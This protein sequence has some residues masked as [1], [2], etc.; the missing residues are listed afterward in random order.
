MIYFSSWVCCPLKFQG[1]PQPHHWECFLVFGNF[2][3][4]KDSLPSMNLHPYLFC[5]SFYLSY[6]FLLPFKDNG[7]P[8]WVPDVPCQH[9][10][11]FCGICSAFKCSFDEFFGE[12]VVSPSYSSTILGPP[13]WL[14]FIYDD[15]LPVLLIWV[16]INS[17]LNYNIN[18]LICPFGSSF[19][20][21]L[22]LLLLLLS[23]F[24][25]VWLCATP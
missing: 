24:S 14:Y 11:L 10:K 18:L 9:S 17:Y 7:L 5:L 4:F 6:F 21:L 3:L 12:K 15:F 22:L 20:H 1:S 19:D 8:F 16:T 2:S 13:P 25:C 23:H